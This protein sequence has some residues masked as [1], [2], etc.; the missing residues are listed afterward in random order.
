M[1]RRRDQCFPS[2]QETAFSFAASFVLIQSKA[3]F[4]CLSS[5]PHFFYEPQIT[6]WQIH[7]QWAVMLLPICFHFSALTAIDKVHNH[8]P[9][10]PTLSMVTG[11][12]LWVTTTICKVHCVRCQHRTFN[13]IFNFASVP[14]TAA[15]SAKILVFSCDAALATT[16]MLMLYWVKDNSSWTH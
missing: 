8:A 11:S 14:T 10:S 5:F 6:S 7:Y 2:L 16:C 13:Y 1:K 15:Q 3:I 4:V 12:A 9:S